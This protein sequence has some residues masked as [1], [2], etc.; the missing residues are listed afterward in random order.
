M[1]VFLDAVYNHFGPEGNYIGCYGPY[2]TA[3][4]K[5]PWGESINFDDSYSHVV[6]DFFI[7]NALY[8]FGECHIDALRLDATDH[9]LDQSAK[10]FLRELA[11]VVAEFSQQQGRNFY[12]TAECDLNNPR[13]VR[14]VALGGF[15]LEA[16]WND[17]FHHALHALVTHETMGYYRD[18]GTLEQM[19]KAYT[20]NYVYTGDFSQNRNRHHGDDPSDCPPTRFVVF[21]QNHDQVGNRLLGDRLCHNISHEGGKLVAA[22]TLLSP[23][24]PLI[25]MGEEYGESA[26]FQ[27]FVSHGDPDLVAAV[28]RGRREEFEA[29]HLDGEAP[30]PQSE[31]TFQKSKLNWDL[32][33]QGEHQQLWQFYQTLLRLR[34][35]IP[36]LGHAD[37]QNLEAKVLEAQS[38]LPLAESADRPRVLQLRRW[39]GSSQVLCLMN[40]NQESATLLISMDG[41]DNTLSEAGLKAG[42]LK[43]RL[44]SADAIWGGPGALAS[45]TLQGTDSKIP[46]IT[47]AAQ[48]AVIYSC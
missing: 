28:R 45:E 10:H 34:R 48:S 25:F 11:E 8:W 27:Y 22:A 42:P 23:S 46:Q 7:Q 24:V 32:R 39:H 20:H 31:A 36:A 29:F 3:K 37:R 47:L 12:L 4:Y 15:G 1:A 5:T 38:D 2:F 26:C 9:I 17:E 16:Q 44:D 41:I 13:W 40:F 43:K 21:N 18:F 14:P 6:R 33:H 35:Q 19:A 30:D